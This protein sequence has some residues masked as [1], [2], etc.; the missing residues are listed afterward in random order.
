M[1]GLQLA[2][3]TYFDIFGSLENT[4]TTLTN[5]VIL[6]FFFFQLLTRSGKKKSL[7]HRKIL[8]IQDGDKVL[9]LKRR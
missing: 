6:I 5:F 1:C 7:N 9:N 3:Q 2:F 8:I 4:A